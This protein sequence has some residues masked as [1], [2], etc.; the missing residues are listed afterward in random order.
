MFGLNETEI[1][2]GYEQAAS[3][4]FDPLRDLSPGFFDG[5]GSAAAL[6]FKDAGGKILQYIAKDPNPEDLNNPI[7]TPRFIAGLAAKSAF[8]DQQQISEVIKK[9]K[10]DPATTGW[11]GQQAFALTSMLSRAI[12]GGVIGGPV[13]GAAVVGGTEQNATTQE[14]I[15]EGVDPQTAERAGDIAGVT[16]GLGAL[17]PA[18]VPG[19]LLTRLASGSAI[20]VATGATYRGST[21]KVLEDGGYKDM[22]EQYKILDAAAIT[23]DAILGAGFGA[24]SRVRR[25]SDVDAALASN[26][27]HQ[28]EVEA[29]PGIPA[30]AATRNAHTEAMDKATEQ[31]VAGEP[32]NVE[33]KAAEF[34]VKPRN[35]ADTD[36]ARA[37][38]EQTYNPA[39][40]NSLG[41]SGTPSL[42]TSTVD[43]YFTQDLPVQRSAQN[44]LSSFDKRA[45]IP[46]GNL[47]GTSNFNIE[48]SSPSSYHKVADLQQLKTIAAELVKPLETKLTQVVDG[49]KGAEFAKVRV[50]EEASLAEK[51]TRKKPE[52]ISDYLGG[53]VTAETPAGL[54]ALLARLR[55]TT[56]VMQVDNFLDGSRSGGYRAIHVQVMSDKGL[57]VEVQIQPKEI[58]QAQDTAHEKYYKKWQQIAK[59]N[60]GK[61]PI[62]RLKE[63]EADMVAQRKLFDEAWTKWERRNKVQIEAPEGIKDF[64]KIAKKAKDGNDFVTQASKIKGVDPEV[65]QWFAD[66]YKGDSTSVAGDSEGFLKDVKAGR[67][68][69][70]KPA[71]TKEAKALERNPKMKI[72]GEDGNVVDANEALQRA[73]AEEAQTKKEASVF[74]A[75]VECFL[76]VGDA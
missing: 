20:N 21:A 32:V 11:L 33:L 36:E 76:E 75:A 57:S 35:A 4:P 61:T 10:P 72:V 59:D 66:R 8:G 25:P 74:Q 7:T 15:G 48:T 73:S 16:T 9:N 62:E 1:Q 24:I 51:L 68:S 58:R 46:S 18:A 43:G 41:E 49:I 47:T 63:Y 31:L 70:K 28:Y 67:Y 17:L 26:D 44:E 30:D 27:W 50:K 19:K 5:A 34:A 29:A 37:L 52:A 54:D 13:G 53:R 69:G 39:A 38:V 22:A 6:G 23:T 2:N 42:E 56:N 12:G 60:G 55:E 45:I 40:V 65:A 71:K 64:V 14:L 3:M